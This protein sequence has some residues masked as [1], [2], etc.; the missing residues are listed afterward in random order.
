MRVALNDLFE[1]P[2]NWLRRARRTDPA[3]SHAA[4]DSIASK[5]TALQEDVLLFALNH[6]AGFTDE[7]LSDFFGC[8]G[9]TYRTRRAELTAKGVIVPTGRRARLKSGRNAV[10]WCH[11]MHW[12]GNDNQGD[13]A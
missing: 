9:S 3:T 12:A 8:R 6:P 4:A 13:A 1:N 2:A 7:M 5:R 11:R 10:L